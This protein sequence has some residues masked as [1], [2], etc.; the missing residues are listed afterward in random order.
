MVNRAKAHNLAA[1]EGDQCLEQEIHVIAGC[2]LVEMH[3]PDWAKAQR[4]DPKVSAVL[5]EG[6]EAY[7]FEGNS[8]RTC[9]QQRR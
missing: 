9:F 7:R 6:T 8:G 2:P 5:D 4:E 1:V 3:V